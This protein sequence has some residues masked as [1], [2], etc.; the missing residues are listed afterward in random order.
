MSIGPNS[1]SMRVAAASTASASA[2]SVG[3]GKARTPKLR[4]CRAASSNRSGSR[5]SRATSHPWR[6][7]SVAVAPPHAGA[8]AGY[9]NDVAQYCAPATHA[10]RVNIEGVSAFVAITKIYLRRHVVDRGLLSGAQ[11]APALP[12]KR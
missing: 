3:I 12:H 6:A 9:Y 11:Q 10:Q 8:G 7:N 5:E 1:S 2:T 4:A